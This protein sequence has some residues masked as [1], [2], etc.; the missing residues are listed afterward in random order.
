MSYW[1]AT[2]NYA[3]NICLLAVLLRHMSTADKALA[4]LATK[5]E[6]LARALA[7]MKTEQTALRQRVTQ[8]EA[9]LSTV[10]K[11]IK[12]DACDDDGSSD[13]DEGSS[14]TCASDTD[15]TCSGFIVNESDATSSVVSVKKKSKGRRTEGGRSQPINI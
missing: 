6:A 3:I 13:G 14:V 15:T 2:T 1:T 10:K 11:H 9:E 4:A 7:S 12:G 8:L 5:T